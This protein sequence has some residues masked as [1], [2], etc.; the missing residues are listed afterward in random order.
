MLLLLRRLIF[1]SLLAVS[2]QW[3]AGSVSL[4]DGGGVK[5]SSLSTGPRG[6]LEPYIA[7]NVGDVIT[8]KIVENIQSL[9]KSQ[10]ILDNDTRS[11]SGLSLQLAMTATSSLTPSANNVANMLTNFSLPVDYSRRNIKEI[12]IDNKEQFFTLVSCLVVEVDPE[13]G[14]MVVEGSRQI[15]MEGE[16]KSLY[17]RGIIFPK[18]IDS[19]NEIPSYKLANAQVQIIDSGTLS[20]ER[21]SGLVQKIFRR[22]F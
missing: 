15:L 9:K 13:N 1:V 18:D 2:F 22:L 8:I 3:P 16:T 17:V 6:Y 20:K 5:S 7:R 10:I 11:D 12:S 21:D 19:N 4:L 14:N